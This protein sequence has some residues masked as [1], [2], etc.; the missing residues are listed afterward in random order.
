MKRSNNSN[1]KILS[2]AV[3]ALSIFWIIPG[4]KKI[5]GVLPDDK[6]FMSEQV[7]FT[8]KTFTPVIGRTN[9]LNGNF[10]ADGSTLPLT[11]EM[12]NVRRNDG[13]AAPE[14]TDSLPTLVW[15]AAYTGQEKSISEIEAKRKLEK[16]PVFEVRKSGELIFWNTSTNT[17]V[18]YFQ[19][20]NS[21]P[22]GTSY[23][24]LFDIKV[25]NSGGSKL[26]KDLVLNPFRERAYDPYEFDPVSNVLLPNPNASIVPTT[27]VGM[28]G[29]DTRKQ[30]SNN[31]A[32][33][34]SDVKVTIV[35]TGDGNSLTFKFL[36][37]NNN[38]INPDL[39]N[40]TKWAT[41]VHGFN[42]QK[43]NEF[44]R[45]D[46]AY[47]IPLIVR[48][49][50]YTTAD[51]SKALVEFSYTRLGFNGIRENGKMTL[52]FNIFR[53]GDWEIN[54]KFTTESPRFEDEF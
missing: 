19:G 47:P 54:F 44:V 12:L 48:P 31:N 26:I 29:I 6:D 17:L 37:R 28:K 22:G 16:H 51:G 15:T 43:T 23:Y 14:L 8:T 52:N 7:D 53:Q 4:C 10:V 24:Y 11:F 27:L 35:R 50:P 1:L 42:M 3:F 9:L 39:F 41:L 30:L 21:A 49:T 18:P 45:Y 40:Q 2:L 33:N 32:T 25:S 13:A 46:I 36:D 20:S 34:N 5:Y 38:S